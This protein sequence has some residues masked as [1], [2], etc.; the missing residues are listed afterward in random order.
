MRGGRET[1][2][3]IL[4]LQV[5]NSSV[6]TGSCRCLHW[7]IHPFEAHV[8][9]RSERRR[10]ED[11]GCWPLPRGWSAGN[12]F[13]RCKQAEPGHVFR[14]EGTMQLLSTWSDRHQKKKPGREW[15]GSW[16]L[17]AL[18]VTLM[19]G[20]VGKRVAK[21][22][23]PLPL[24]QGAACA[25]ISPARVPCTARVGGWIV[26]TVTWCHATGSKACTSMEVGRIGPSWAGSSGE[27]AADPPAVD[28]WHPRR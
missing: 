17:A 25:H 6:R 26:P 28:S 5:I 12:I 13:T 15:Q 11:G 19:L 23:P 21:V 22:P 4:I 14:L 3:K 2:R 20:C 8:A 1:G 18:K 7:A 24:C 27:E 10:N 16:V 9:W